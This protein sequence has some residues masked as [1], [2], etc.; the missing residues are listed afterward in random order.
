VFFDP[1]VASPLDAAAISDGRAVGSAAVFERSVGGR[2]LEFRAGG[3][4]G[5]FRDVQ[6]GSTWAITG[7][8]TAGDLVGEQLERI[9]HD[10]QFWFAVAAFFDEPEIRG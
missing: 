3:K 1:D 10:D 6:T 4:A 9:P 7:E 5:T 2:A 8:A